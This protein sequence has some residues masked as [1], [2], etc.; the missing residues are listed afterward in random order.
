ML[1]RTLCAIV[2]ALLTLMPL[3]GCGNSAPAEP[4]AEPTAVPDE[5][6]AWDNLGYDMV[7]IVLDDDS[8]LT[9]AVDAPLSGECVPYRLRPAPVGVKE[10]LDLLVNA[11]DMAGFVGSPD[12]AEYFT[13][14]TIDQDSR[15]RYH[16]IDYRTGLR[17]YEG[18]LEE[19]TL[20]YGSTVAELMIRRDEEQSQGIADYLEF[21]TPRNPILHA[22]AL[23]F[24]TPA[25][26]FSQAEKLLS[27]LGTI[28]KPKAEACVSMTHQALMDYQKELYDRDP[29]YDPDGKALALENLTDEDDAYLIR[30]SFTCDGIPVRGFYGDPDLE[31]DAPSCKAWADMVVTRRGIIYLNVENAL[32]QTELMQLNEPAHLFHPIGVGQQAKADW[33]AAALPPLDGENGKI[34]VIFLEYLPIAAD[35]GVTLTPCW[36]CWR[37]LV[38]TDPDTNLK[39]WQL[40]DTAA[41]Y[42]AVTGDRLK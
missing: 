21:C 13:I 1:K 5:T 19:E 30:L 18:D 26:V 24:A 36:S 15:S 38:Q 40:D 17:F 11:Q 31:T 27:D 4:T 34:S 23:D 6:T 25:H 28:F 16:I 8:V 37:E 32:Y 20:S 42:H 2:T 12:D 35:D 29:T 7:D 22:D 41:R 10:K 14:D 9:V 3:S 33:D 39:R